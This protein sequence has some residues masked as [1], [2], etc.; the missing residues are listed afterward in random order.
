MKSFYTILHRVSKPSLMFL[1]ISSTCIFNAA[2]YSVSQ[3]S[4]TYRLGQVFITWTNPSASNLQYNVYRSTTK[5]TSSTQLS[6]GTYMGFVRDNSAKNI[7]MSQDQGNAKYFKI[8]GDGLPL[9]STKGLYVITCTSNQPY[10]YAVTVTNLITNLEDKSISIGQ[11]SLSNAVMETVQKPQPVFQDSIMSNGNEMKYRYVQFVNNQE[12]P[13]YPAMTSVGSYGFNFYIVQRGTSSSF[14]LIVIF[15]SSGSTGT[16]GV[17]VDPQFTNCCILGLSDFLPLPVSGGKLGGGE[18]TYFFG[19]HEDFNIYSTAGIIPLKGTIKTYTA[20]RN[21]EAI[22]WVKSVL[23][24]DKSR[25][26]LKGTSST[27]FGALVTAMLYP[28][29][30]AAVYALVEPMM[31][32]P[33]GSKSTL[34]KLMWGNTSDDLLSDALDPTTLEPLPAYTILDIRKMVDVN[35][36]INMPLIF[37]VHGKKDKTV[38]WS[39]TMIT[40]FDSLNLNRVG[41]VFSWDQR[42]HSGSG[43]NFLTEETIPNF[44]RYQTT[45]SYPAFSNCSINQNPGIGTSTSGD[46]YGAYNGYLDWDDQITDEECEYSVNVFVK[47]YYVGGVLISDQYST[48]K[49]DISFRRLQNFHPAVGATIAWKN[50]NSSNEIIQSGS[51]VFKGDLMTITNLTVNKSSN[52]IELKISNCQRNTDVVATSNEHVYFTPSFGGYTVHADV[53]EDGEV[54][55]NMFDLLGKNLYHKQVMMTKGM[56]TLEIASEGHGMYLVELKGKSFSSVNKLLF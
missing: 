47:N 10:Y 1:I 27:G 17:N 41:G 8:T 9:A 12:T 4:T 15:N 31:I 11:N 16:N 37:D 43:K 53:S 51:F 19:Y 52:K 55:V 40:W 32:K 56:N 7:E 6:S 45:K 50:Y 18:D 28:N 23:P 29:E 3:I 5:F 25:V 30:I 22:R 38:P 42:T 20:K 36:N 26:Y 2:A 49:T 13:L 54:L 48:C 46:P 35:E 39:T 33:T 34:Y 21:I 24:I 14:P 44:Y